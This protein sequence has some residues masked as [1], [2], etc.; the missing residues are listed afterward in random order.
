MP[1]S[2]VSSRFATRVVG[3]AAV[4]VV[5]CHA[6][7]GC[8]SAP[9]SV[10]PSASSAAAV[11][12]R[13]AILVSFDALNERRARESLPAGALPAFDAL[14]EG[15][16]CAASA[17][18]AFP[19]VTAPGHAALWTGTYG[20]VNGIAANDMPVLPRNAHPITSRVSGYFVN[21]LRAEPVW[22]TTARAGR[23]VTGHHVT[24]A[25]G[26]P[27]YEG[28]DAD[29]PTLAARKREALAVLGR[30]DLLVMNGYNATRS[31]T[32]VLSHETHAPQPARGWRQLDRLA[33]DVPP[34][35]IAWL[36][37]SDSLFA[38]LHGAPG[39]RRY[40]RV[41]LAPA[42]D[43][44]LGR[45]AV[46]APLDTAAITPDRALARHF[47]EPVF[48]R[49]AQGL[50]TLTGRLFEI[51]EDGQQYLLLVPELRYV[52]GNHADD[53]EAYLRAI[54]GWYGNGA[55][56][57]Y[58]AGRLGPTLTNGGDGTAE[59]RYVESLELLVRQFERG[60]TWL[61]R[62]R[63]PHLHLDY[64]PLIDEVDHE[65]FG[66]MDSTAAGHDAALARSLAPHRTR[67]WQ[68]A[69][70]FLG[71]LQGLVAGD[72]EAMLVVSGD[73]GMRSYWRGFRPNVVLRDAGLLVLDSAGRVDLSRTK[74]YS[75]TG[76]FVMVNR[77]AW[78]GGIVGPLEEPAVIDAI[79]RAL[80]AAQTPE[81]T[82]VITRTWRS[83]QPG[84]DTLG[85]GGPSGGDVYYD[86][87]R[88]Y[89]WN[90]GLTGEA[91]VPLRAVLAGHG[92][93]S[94]SPEMHTV[95][96]AWGDGIAPRRV[97]PLRSADAP[98]VI[99][100]WLGTPHPPDATGESPFTTLIAPRE[101]AGTPRR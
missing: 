55:M 69:D 82:P 60:A 85:I 19:S 36:A 39:M 78:Q 7:V 43:V 61:W 42:R 5:L 6:L 59:A 14:F 49:D 47:A 51:S 35:E 52:Q 95:L 98:L 45:V 101:R 2:I 23:R 97:G 67:A 96:C 84:A 46:L 44:A 94:P 92:Y 18:P 72:P 26:A 56:S 1:A 81:R 54:G 32:L 3:R 75:P 25:P 17:R 79:E 34:L 58:R 33:S 24:Q 71:T 16:A 41:L 28:T 64:L 37:G 48:V 11:S 50:V 15:G 77:T 12:A 21:N 89:Y 73:H 90:A 29:E 100:D 40:D 22:I 63:A 88:G 76:Y 62:T 38:L 66:R 99:T 87:A 13:R 74:A 57:A 10:T 27:G 68:L 8:A 83:D 4:S 31:P 30:D 93:P 70:R 9:A 65:W 53:T 91:T 80:R 86:V 20:R